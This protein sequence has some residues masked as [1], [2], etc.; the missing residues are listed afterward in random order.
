MMDSGIVFTP[1]LHVGAITQRVYCVGIDGS[2]MREVF[3]D[4]TLG[5]TIPI[6]VA[7]GEKKARRTGP[8]AA[9]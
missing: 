5:E 7:N 9:S 2:T 3:P 6:A 8:P 1:P 4:G